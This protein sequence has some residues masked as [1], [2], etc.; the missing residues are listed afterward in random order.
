MKKYEAQQLAIDRSKMII[1]C[2][3]N[4]LADEEFSNN[5]NP[6]KPIARINFNYKKINN[7]T[8]CIVDILVPRKPE[9]EK[10]LNLGITHNHWEVLYEKILDDLLDYLESDTIGLSKFYEEHS[11]KGTFSGVDLYNLNKCCIKINFRPYSYELMDEYNR[12]YKE[13][14]IGLGETNNIRR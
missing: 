1:D 8:I 9:Y 5:V 12:K 14:S 7:E 11:I 6:L 10:H 4:I 13:K 2:I 3:N